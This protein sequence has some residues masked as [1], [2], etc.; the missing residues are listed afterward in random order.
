[1]NH[2]TALHRPNIVSAKLQKELV[3]GHFAGLFD[4]PPF[5][6][7]VN[8]PL[9]LVPKTNDQGRDLPTEAPTDPKSYH[10]I[11]DLRKS[12]VNSGIPKMEVS[13]EY[14]KFDQI[15]VNCFPYDPGCH[16]AKTDIKSAFRLIAIN[17]R[18]WPYLCMTHQGKY[19]VDK[20][21]PFGLA[22]S[23]AI[24]EEFPTALQAI[25]QSRKPVG[26]LN[27]YLNDYIGQ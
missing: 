24:F 7:Q 19:F 8:N 26:T 27:H 1:M 25:A 14:T 2:P 16:L 9:G 13:V 15:I 6:S 4:S 5:D 17:P 21:L 22:T 20:C 23:C 11:T 12:G 10:L 3:A 18:D